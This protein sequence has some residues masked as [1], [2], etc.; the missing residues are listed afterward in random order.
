MA[1]RPE[2]ETFF[3]SG[4]VAFFVVMVVFY[5]GFWFALYALMAQRS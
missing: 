5:V 4:A 1:R 2:D 3:P